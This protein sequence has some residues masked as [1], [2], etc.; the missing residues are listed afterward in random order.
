MAVQ[1]NVTRAVPRKKRRRFEDATINKVQARLVASPALPALTWP[2]NSA[3]FPPPPTSLCSSIRHAGH[4]TACT[5]CTV[6]ID[7]AQYCGI[8][9]IQH[10]SFFEN[11]S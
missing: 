10:R 11:H 5:H 3:S 9:R 6:G 7:D 4:K 8:A 2:T 1:G